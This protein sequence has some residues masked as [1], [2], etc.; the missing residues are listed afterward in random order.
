MSTESQRSDAGSLMSNQNPAWEDVT[1][2]VEDVDD[3][4]EEMAKAVFDLSNDYDIKTDEIE[5]MKPGRF[6]RIFNRL[7][8]FKKNSQKD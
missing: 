1:H 3:V 5:K 8:I 4:T 6:T 2:V 7:R